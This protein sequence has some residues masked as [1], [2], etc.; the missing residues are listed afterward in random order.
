MYTCTENW[1]C[2][3]LYSKM[4]L[5][6]LVQL[7]CFVYTC[8]ESDVV[9]LAV[10]AIKAALEVQKAVFLH[11]VGTLIVQN[12]HVASIKIK[13]KL[14]SS[15]EP[16]KCLLNNNPPSGHGSCRSQNWEVVK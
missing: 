8:T 9:I 16:S 3:H 4:V 2:V 1:L 14:S 15:Q 10:L 7:T 11:N 13:F 6:T 12:L 5:S